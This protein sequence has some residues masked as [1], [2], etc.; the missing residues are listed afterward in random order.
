MNTVLQEQYGIHITPI[1]FSSFYQ[2]NEQT[3]KKIIQKIAFQ[4]PEQEYFQAIAWAKKKS[5]ENPS[6]R[7]A[8]V[9]PQIDEKRSLLQEAAE[10]N[11]PESLLSLDAQRYKQYMNISGG[12]ALSH[13]PL[14]KTFLAIISLG[15]SHA[16]FNW[17]HYLLSSPY[18]GKYMDISTQKQA[19]NARA[20]WQRALSMDL[21]NKSEWSLWLDYLTKK[22]AS[23]PTHLQD[24]IS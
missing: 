18:I 14:V 16:D 22:N 17:L 8:I 9:V 4:K 19:M 24:D 21:K 15:F 23:N 20:D 10:K 12:F 6:A 7:I 13:V 3:E 2:K 11:W 5:E 1:H